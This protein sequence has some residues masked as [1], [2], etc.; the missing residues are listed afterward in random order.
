MGVVGEYCRNSEVKLSGHPKSGR[1]NF[2]ENFPL[3][4]IM[5]GKPISPRRT[6]W[7]VVVKIKESW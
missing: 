6:G 1:Q 3:P 2:H 5:S 7:V 4:G